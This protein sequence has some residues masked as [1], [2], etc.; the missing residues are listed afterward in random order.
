MYGCNLQANPPFR[1]SNVVL[2]VREIF[3]TTTMPGDWWTPTI[4]M[5]LFERRHSPGRA[6]DFCTYSLHSPQKLLHALHPCLPWA[7][8]FPLSL[9]YPKQAPTLLFSPYSFVPRDPSQVGLRDFMNIIMF[10]I[11][12]ISSISLFDLIRHLSWSKR[13]SLHLFIQKDGEHSNQ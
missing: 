13:S 3:T 6:S 8:T 11:P 9:R 12:R 7:S 4:S 5:H 10:L 1:L 2:S